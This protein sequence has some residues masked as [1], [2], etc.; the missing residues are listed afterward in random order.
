MTAM[1][2]IFMI[3]IT[4]SPDGELNGAFAVQPDREVCETKMPGIVA[5]VETSG[6]VV[7]EAVC[8]SGDWPF[9]RFLH[10]YE[11]EDAAAEPHTYLVAFDNGRSQAV[12]IT[13][14]TKK[15]ACTTTSENGSANSRSYCVSS[16]QRW[17][18]DG[19]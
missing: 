5:V 16:R 18:S 13:Q 9:D 11:D 1:L 6:V 15:S 12:T 17:K 3:L 8:A 10:A 14:W 2:E 19:E 4:Q 7:R